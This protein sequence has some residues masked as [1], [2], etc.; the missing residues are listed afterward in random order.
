MVTLYTTIRLKDDVVASISVLDNYSSR[1]K[2]FVGD[3]ARSILVKVRFLN[4]EDRQFII[5]S[6][7]IT[8]GFIFDM[9][10]SIDDCNQRSDLFQEMT[11][12]QF[13]EYLRDML[14]RMF[15]VESDSNRLRNADE[16]KDYFGVKHERAGYKINWRSSN[17]PL[18]IVKESWQNTNPKKHSF[19]HSILKRKDLKWLNFSTCSDSLCRS[20]TVADDEI[21]LLRYD[22]R[23][24]TNGSSTSVSFSR[25]HDIDEVQSIVAKEILAHVGPFAAEEKKYISKEWL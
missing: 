4:S 13:C 25:Y 5:V 10:Q 15:K 20:M 12:F 21:L 8:S 9:K 19:I 2:I 17:Q 24:S 7:N 1:N 16:V 22:R 11:S 23:S 3:D 18:S 14:A 6:N